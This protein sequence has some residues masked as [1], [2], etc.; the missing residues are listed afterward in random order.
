MAEITLAQQKLSEQRQRVWSEYCKELE[1]YDAR[2]ATD[3]QRQKLDRMDADLAEYD[4]RLKAIHTEAE[5]E[6]AADEQRANRIVEQRASGDAHPFGWSKMEQALRAPKEE[7]RGVAF[8]IDMRGVSGPKR[9]FEK[10]AEQYEERVMGVGSASAG[11]ALVPT[12]FSP[13][14]YRYLIQ[15]SAIRN[16]NVRVVTT[17]SGDNYVQPSFSAYSSEATVV[18]AGAAIGANDPT[19]T[20]ATLSAYKFGTLWQVQYELLQDSAYDLLNELAFQFGRALANGE[21][22]AFLLGASGGPSGII[23]N[24]GTVYQYV[25]GTPAANGP[26]YSDLVET[27]HKVIPP[28]RINSTWMFN[29]VTLKDL[30]KL[31]DT[32]GRPLWTPGLAGF[33]VDVPDT[34]LGKPYVIDPYMPNPGVGATSIVYGDFSGVTIREV[35]GVRLER[36]DD[37]AFGNDLAT[38]RILHRVDCALIDTHGALATYKGGTA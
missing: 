14:L 3:E 8:E 31:T 12:E 32:Q 7:A 15:N 22:K 13:L 20:S 16:T 28:Y 11:G 9:N 26:T 5:R 36:S 29:D 6:Q 34:L 23:P 38:F 2:S 25:G 37:Y 35:A 27:M 21:G 24:A 10:R 17:D 4:K 18:S 1:T 33:G 19:F 30:R